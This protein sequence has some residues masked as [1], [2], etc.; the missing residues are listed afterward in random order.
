MRICL[1]LS[2]CLC[3]FSG[4]ELQAQSV[5]SRQPATGF[6]LSDNSPLSRL[7]TRDN[8]VTPASFLGSN[9]KLPP[10][11]SPSASSRQEI[12]AILTGKKQTSAQT[13]A[14]Q[15]QGT[16]TA[17]REI[18]PLNIPSVP[19][20]NRSGMQVDP[21]RQ[22]SSFVPPANTKSSTV[23][24]N[25]ARPSATPRPSTNQGGSF[26]PGSIKSA[27]S[28]QGRSKQAGSS[29]FQSNS[30]P[31][32][33]PRI[34]STTPR[35]S[36]NINTP[37]ANQAPRIGALK[38][39]AKTPTFDQVRTSEARN[40]SIRSNPTANSTQPNV[41]S[42]Q[43]LSPQIKVVSAG[44]KSL[45][46]NKS[47]KYEIKIA[48]IGT[49]DASEVMV[50]IEIPSWVEIVGNPVASGGVAEAK[51]FEGGKG[52]V[53]SV[54]FLPAGRDASV[55]MD[56]MPK[57][58]RA[59]N[60]KT[61]WTTAPV[62]NESKIMVTQPNLMT[63][64]AGPND[65][66]YGEKAVYKITIE[67]GGNGPAEKVAVSLSDSLGG[68][69]ANVGN[70]EAGATKQFEVELT[71]GQAGPLKLQAF[72]TGDAGVKSE[73]AKDIVVRRGKLELIAKGPEFKYAGSAVTY[74]VTVENRGDAPAKNITAASLLPVGA[75]YISGLTQV[76]E[77]DGRKIGWTI[78]EIPANSKR[79]FT[80]TCLIKQAGEARMEFGVRSI[81]G[82]TA[83]DFVT[84]KVEALADLTL[85]VVDPR[86]PQAVGRD[87]IYEL[88]I[89]NR[90]TKAANNVMVSGEFSDNIDPVAGKGAVAT[91][92]G[93]GVIT[94]A[95][96][97]MINVGESVIL[98]VV[99]NSKGPGTHTFRAIVECKAQDIRRVSEG[100]TKFFGKQLK[101]TPRVSRPNSNT[102]S[103]DASSLQPAE[104]PSTSLAP[105]S[106]APTT[107][108]GPSLSVPSTPSS[109]GFA[110]ASGSFAP[111]S[112][113]GNGSTLPP[114]NLNLG[115]GGSFQGGQ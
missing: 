99:A 94:F 30:V 114:T 18:D 112:N 28:G 40:T 77:N 24:Q 19:I 21:N 25:N 58:N 62:S 103:L 89:K 100:T 67:N 42:S 51:T 113:N 5:P 115:S 55:V 41:F 39:R 104:R 92:K 57:E 26:A 73:I 48:N 37:A 45:S 1:F 52:V 35:T 38:N 106:L 12:P 102:P 80:L 3:S 95:P 53:W 82:L 23:Q 31:Q 59:F 49:I 33:T 70:I 81:G 32:T 8:K 47:G 56:L 16:S 93:D 97:R 44:P 4:L 34:E 63:S 83:A 69:S 65:V 96:I 84:T 15:R 14:S 71:A 105:T 61:E 98:K 36:S 76:T 75:E 46:V 20:G 111:P 110:P 87:V 2:V 27:N 72:V 29:S 88:H 74:N 101:S 43:R 17:K 91:I 68:D 13:Q 66:K 108:N 10:L 9:D 78:G 86:G 6:R 11:N 90:G 109:S 107:G 7:S 60:L 85:E 79:E 64:I 50:G 22:P 54:S